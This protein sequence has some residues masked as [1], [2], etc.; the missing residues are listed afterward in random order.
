M[1]VRGSADRTLS[2]TPAGP[3][4]RAAIALELAD[5]TKRFGRTLA[6]DGAGIVARRGT[7]HALL[8]ENG[9][10]K[11]TLMR[12]AFGMIR[13]DAGTVTLDGEREEF[14]SPSD[15]IAH[16]L[17]MV[18]QHFTLVPAMTVAENLALGGRG[19]YR[20]AEARERVRDVAG[21]AGLTID[22]DARAGDLPVSA[23]QRV[24]ILK[25]LAHG[26][27]IL[28]LD[29]PTAVLT[30]AESRELLALLR[31]F[32]HD[33]GTAILITHKLRD[34]L[35]VADDITV[36]RHGRTA[37]SGA[38]KDATEATLVS[39]MVGTDREASDEAR[40]LSA[41]A[42]AHSVGGAVLSLRDVTI[43]GPGARDRLSHATLDVR[44]GEIVGVAAVE[45]SG[46]YELLRV[47][48]GRLRPDAG[49]ARLPARVGFVPEDRQHDALI[50]ELTLTENVALSGAG[51]RRGRMRWRDERTRTDTLMHEYDVRARDASVRARQ[52]SG[53]NQQKLVVGREL[54]ST[55]DAIVAENPSRGLDFAATAAVH[56]RLRAARDA[57]RAV[58]MYSSDLDEILALAD[59][60]VVVH[61]GRM[62]EVARDREAIGRA[63]LGAGD[64]SA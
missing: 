22:P 61:A 46:Q 15:A 49:S 17:G 14:H 43:H 7:V 24:E 62:R 42:S 51:E 16:G 4:P 33:G 60:V 27:R 10:G 57:G 29:E 56:D 53:G 21:R 37:W 6:L 48:A 47:L 9:A 25:A 40:A 36:L 55:D 39:A 34:A 3:P 13:A 31:T 5:V 41:P 64:A 30:P 63:M 59:R 2:D 50:G 54:E 38:A 11:T 20:P 19:A 18:H 12:V 1:D 35:E 26:G 44:A 32:A 28:I 23:Q 58:V 45:G 8:G 52:L